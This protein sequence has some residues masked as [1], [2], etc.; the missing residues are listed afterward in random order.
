MLI[1]T[2]E[3]ADHPSPTCISPLSP[4]GENFVVSFT[5]ASILVYDTRTGEE[6]IGMASNESYDG[7]PATGITSVV[8]SSQYLE[9]TTQEANRGGSDEDGIHG[10]T[11]SNSGG[12]VE[13]VIIS[14]HEDHLIRFFDANS[15][16]F[17]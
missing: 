8:T 6:L 11:G 12:G 15:G 1:H 13:G 9:G 17:L 16:K 10:P 14:G 5:D 4:T 2:I 7:T 3:R